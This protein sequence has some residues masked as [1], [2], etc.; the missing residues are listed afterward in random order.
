MRGTETEK[1]GREAEALTKSTRRKRR[2]CEDK[3][4]NY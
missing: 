2:R 4:W 1:E 3:K